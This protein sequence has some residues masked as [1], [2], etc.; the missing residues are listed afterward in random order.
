MPTIN[1]SPDNIV[2]EA[3][4]YQT[5]LQSL[6]SQE[7][8][9]V[10]ACGG[11][12]I[13]STC[14][15]MILDG[16]E[17]CT[18]MTPSEKVLAEK[19]D[20]PVHIRLAC[21]TKVKGDISI[22]RLVI[23]NEDI[24]VVKNQ[25]AVGSIGTKKTV[26]ILSASIRGLTNFDEVN[27]PYDMIYTLGRYYYRMKSVI[28]QHGGVINGYMGLRLS[29]LFGIDQ[30]QK[31][32][33][34]SVEKAIRA[35][36]E[37]IE[38]VNELNETLQQLSYRKISLSIGIHYGSAVLIY[39]DPHDSTKIVAVGNSINFAGRVE[40]ANHGVSSSLLVSEPVYEMIKDKVLV[41][42]RNGLQ[43]PTKGGSFSVFE[44]SKIR[45][46]PASDFLPEYVPESAAPPTLLS[47]IKSLIKAWARF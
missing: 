37:M 32:S 8:R 46:D 26:A 12:A 7:I 33:D 30:P 38:S 47:T 28:H 3:S 5:I 24:E 22:Q 21:Q 34:S 41:G 40:L 13:C 29:A 10:H 44:I 6:L 23:D 45:F 43:L 25:V 15:V 16:I 4:P 17:N 20:L 11:N 9:H 36:L 42:D 27:F 35:G 2:V 39:V 18:I 1:C 14:R 19:L 31:K